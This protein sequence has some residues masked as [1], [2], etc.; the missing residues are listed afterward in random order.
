MYFQVI[1]KKFQISC[2]AEVA[3]LINETVNSTL[4]QPTAFAPDVTFNMTEDDSCQ[5]HYF[6]FNSQVTIIFVFS[7]ED[8]REENREN[9]HWKF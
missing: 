5:P 1:C 6:I 4:A 9:T 7:E 2:P 3:F 8:F